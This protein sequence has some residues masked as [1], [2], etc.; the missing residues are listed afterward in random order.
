[1][2]ATK[3]IY[4]VTAKVAEAIHEP[5]LKWQK[6]EAA[7]KIIATGHFDSFIIARLKDVDDS[8]GPTY[9]TQYFTDSLH[10]INAFN[11]THLEAFNNEAYSKWDGQFI[12]FRTIME[13]VH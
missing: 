4:N 12:A 10:N 13:V 3:Y 1:M 7:P 2:S 5:W 6:E 8:E 9:V 11:Q